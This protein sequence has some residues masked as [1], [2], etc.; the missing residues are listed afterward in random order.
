MNKFAKYVPEADKKKQREFI[1][2]MG[3][4]DMPFGET[5]DLHITWDGV[6]GDRTVIE[7]MGV[8]MSVKLSDET[9]TLDQLKNG[10]YV[11]YQID[12]GPHTNPIVDDELLA[13]MEEMGLITSQYIVCPETVIV[14]YEDNVTISQGEMS[15]TIPEKG[16]YVTIDDDG[17]SY[18]SELHIPGAIRTLD[19]KYL[20][21]GLQIG[22][23]LLYE[24]VYMRNMITSY[25][26]LV[27]GGYVAPLFYH[28]GNYEL[29]IGARYRVIIND[30]TY[31]VIAQED[32]RGRG[33]LTCGDYY[34]ESEDPGVGL[35]SNRMK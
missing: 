24:P 26:E 3:L 32:P 15:I 35:I 12:R 4:A 30:E 34:I 7:M 5:P 17:S 29:Q 23:E 19:S 28:Y 13:D 14:A 2:A 16:I 27:D 18:I 33:A 8:P 6:V 21:E 25:N 22:E 1:G 10:T 9:P 31:D 11:H 20:P